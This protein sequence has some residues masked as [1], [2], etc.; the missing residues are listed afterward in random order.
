LMATEVVLYSAPTQE[1]VPPDCCRS[2]SGK[3]RPATVRK[4]NVQQTV[5]RQEEPPAVASRPPPH[6]PVSNLPDASC[7]DRNE[8]QVDALVQQ[9]IARNPSLAQM[10]AAWQA[11]S[12][13]YPQVTSLEDPMLAATLGPGTFAPDDPGINFAYRVEI[14]QKYPWPGKLK[15]RGQTA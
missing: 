7:L 5:A 13:K 11:V 8:L 3:G 12:A 14:S 1:A 10:V 15:L 2:P 9:V 4:M 6:P